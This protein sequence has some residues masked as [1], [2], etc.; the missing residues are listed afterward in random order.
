MLR[1]ARRSPLDPS[2]LV[3]VASDPLV[4]A[5]ARDASRRLHGPRAI[6]IVSGAEALHRLVGPGQPPS[7]M[8]LQGGAAGAMLLS[9]ARDRFSATEVI[10][11]A[12]PGEEVPAGLRAVPAVGARLAEALAAPRPPHAAPA[13]DAAALAAGLARGEITVRFQPVVRL[14]D[15][16]PV[17]VEALARWERPEAAHGAGAFIA[18]AEA[19][20]LATELTLAVARRALAGLG[21][22]RM[23]LSFNVSLSALLRRDLPSRLAAMIAEAGVHPGDVL[24]ELTESTAVRDTALL[25]RALQ[26]LATVGLGVLLDDLGLD[27]SRS[28]LLDLPFRGVKLDRALIAALPHARR[29]RAQVERLVQDAH[30]RGRVVIAEGV[31]DPL[32]WRLTAAAGCD[33]AQGFGVGRPILPEA[34]PGWTA[35][36][37]AAALPGRQPAKASR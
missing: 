5:A 27:D 18:M 23:L 11:V 26:R 29:A 19:A 34:L 22:K 3:L 4:I 8:V 24:L 17:M 6:Q 15:R 33:L 16:R 21:R 35:A 31:T 7:H 14:A 30:R 25:R 37:G 2:S 13:G 28:G 9:A 32:L 12:R 10:V 1:R 36:W 20:G